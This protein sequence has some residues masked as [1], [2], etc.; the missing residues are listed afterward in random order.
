MATGDTRAVPAVRIANDLRTPRSAAVAGIIFALILGA[1]IVL[2]RSAGPIRSGGDTSWLT[3]PARRR[4]VA[5]SLNL[6]PFAGIAF[7]WFIGVIRSRLGDRE[8]RLFATVFLGSGLLFVGMLFTG[9]GLLSAL[10]NL[11][12]RSG[13]VSAD[14]VG[15]VQ[16]TTA[17]LLGTFGARMAAVFTLSV[18]TAGLRTHILPRWLAVAG[19][20]A[21]VALFLS[22]PISNWAQLVFPCWVLVLSLFILASAGHPGSMERTSDARE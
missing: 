6:I 9:A 14:T 20:A 3:D 13:A 16:N 22:P 8:D 10:L 18:T 2:F 5:L 19:Y 4:E 21:A 12:A 7:L 1:A 15:L 11:E 17:I